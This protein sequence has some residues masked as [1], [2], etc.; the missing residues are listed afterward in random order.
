M[1]FSA[2]PSSCFYFPV[3]VPFCS[4]CHLSKLLRSTTSCSLIPRLKCVCAQVRD[5]RP[6][7]AG[8]QAGRQTQSDLKCSMRGAGLEEVPVIAV[9]EVRMDS[10]RPKATQQS[11]IKGGNT[12]KQHPE[13]K[14]GALRMC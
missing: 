8:G 1:R 3:M 4:S 14:C 12:H 11:L 9:L 6:W 2:L 7:E 10:R 5:K 13:C